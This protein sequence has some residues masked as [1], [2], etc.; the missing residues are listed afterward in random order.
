MAR[1]GDVAIPTSQSASSF[2]VRILK[3]HPDSKLGIV[4]VIRQE[5]LHPEIETLKVGGLG[6]ASNLLQPGDLIIAVNGQQVFCDE[7]ASKRIR[8]AEHEVLLE[9]ERPKNAKTKHTPEFATASFPLS[10][11]DCLFCGKCGPWRRSGVVGKS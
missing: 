4:L 1:E 5:S 8:E 11:S 10:L 6:H 7:A 2:Q 9:V 3:P